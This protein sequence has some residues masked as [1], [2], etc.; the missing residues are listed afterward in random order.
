MLKNIG[1][2]SLKAMLWKQKKHS[3]EKKTHCREAEQMYEY[4]D[5]VKLREKQKQNRVL[6]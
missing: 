3:N 6:K 1:T 5:F 2:L 4:M